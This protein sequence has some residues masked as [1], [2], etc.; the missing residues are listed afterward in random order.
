MEVEEELSTKGDLF[1]RVSGAIQRNMPSDEEPI[2]EKSPYSVIREGE[3]LPEEFLK[4]VPMEVVNEMENIERTDQDLD[5]KELHMPNAWE[6]M[7]DEERSTLSNAS[8]RASKIPTANFKEMYN[9]SDPEAFIF[10]KV[11]NPQDDIPASLDD[12]EEAVYNSAIDK[13]LRRETGA[14]EAP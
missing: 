6:T 13:I 3:S 7:T 12:E 4:D 14:Q 10:Q 11:Q 8:E 9:L 1:G 2:Q 5:R